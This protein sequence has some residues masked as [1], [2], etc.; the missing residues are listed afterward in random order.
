MKKHTKTQ[1]AKHSAAGHRLIRAAKQALAHARSTK[2]RVEIA[3]DALVLRFFDHSRKG[4]YIAAWVWV[5]DE[6]ARA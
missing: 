1:S 3:N 4:A 6:E 2:H 5:S